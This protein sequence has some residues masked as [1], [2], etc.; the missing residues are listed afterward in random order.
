MEKRCE[1]CGGSFVLGDLVCAWTL[2]KVSTC[3][4]EHAECER[5]CERCM[6]AD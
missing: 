5:Y 3:E 6:E 1:E 2:E 4:C